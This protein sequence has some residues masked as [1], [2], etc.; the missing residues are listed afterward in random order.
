MI[1][2]KFPQLYDKTGNEQETPGHLAV[3]EILSILAKYAGDVAL[4]TFLKDEFLTVIKPNGDLSEQLF[5]LFKR[6]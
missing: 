4:Q 5:K 3:H 6:E 2:D 1:I